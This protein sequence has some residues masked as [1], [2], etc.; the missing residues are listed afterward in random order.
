MRYESPYPD[1]KLPSFNQKWPLDVLLNN[2][3]SFS[4]LSSVDV[5]E[6]VFDVIE[7]FDPSSLIQPNRFDEPHIELAVF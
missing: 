6:N 3:T 7:H 5:S 1:V 4:L 2:E